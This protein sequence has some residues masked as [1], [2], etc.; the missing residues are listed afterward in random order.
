[1]NDEART[2]G[3]NDAVRR[4]G[5][6]PEVGTALLGLAKQDW[7]I[8]LGFFALALSAVL[9]V[10]GSRATAIAEKAL[11]SRWFEANSP[12]ILGYMSDRSFDNSRVKLHPIFPLVTYP[13]ISTITRIGKVSPL[14]AV[15]LLNAVTAGVWLGTLYL[16]MRLLDCRLLDSLLFT[17][18]AASSGAAMFWF[19]VPETYPLGSLTLLLPLGLVAL[20][21]HRRVPDWWFVTASA[22][23]L[24]ITLTNWMAGLIA[25]FVCKPLRRA[26]ALSLAALA[27]TAVLVLVQRTAFLHANASFIS[28]RGYS[29]IK[30]W[31][32]REEQGGALN[33]ARVLFLTSAVVPRIELSGFESQ[34]GPTGPMLTIQRAPMGSSG[35]LGQVA[36]IAWGLLLAAGAVALSVGRGD[37][38]FRIALV[39]T[40]LGQTTIYLV[41]GE[42]TFLY[43]LHCVPLLI[44]AASLATLSRWR[45]FVLAVAGLLL[46]CAAW[47]NA[48]Q[49]TEALNLPPRPTTSGVRIDSRF[50]MHVPIG[51]AT[52]RIGWG[53]PVQYSCPSSSPATR[54]RETRDRDWGLALGCGLNV[55]ALEEGVFG[56]SQGGIAA[57]A[58]DVGEIGSDAGAVLKDGVILQM[59]M[60]VG[61]A[62]IAAVAAEGEHLALAD[63]VALVDAQ[64]AGLEMRVDGVLAG[65][66]VN[67]QAVSDRAQRVH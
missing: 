15:W 27:I 38:R 41:Y 61:L 22:A 9:F 34:Q 53:T 65:A 40:L 1:M 54:E 56:I 47:N 23:S 48:R 30:R 67:D 45:Y 17:S 3:I 46:P 10:T 12:L 37:A 43:A 6:S 11:N 33:A 64:G 57:A 4:D 16:I 8:A 29:I 59:K 44:L 58:L 52:H 50:E 62:G 14:E 32:Q 42:E 63:L 5:R 26:F 25:A 18:I 21:R 60:E 55:V 49:L 24:S 66:L 13:L 20:A 28:P 19:I 35:I 31:V 7:V 51:V 39:V 2:R 36:T